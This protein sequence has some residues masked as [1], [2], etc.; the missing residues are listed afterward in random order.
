MMNNNYDIVYISPE[1]G[2]LILENKNNVIELHPLWLRERALNKDLLDPI[3]KQRKY[4]HSFFDTNLKVVSAKISNYPS[5]EITFSD[6]FLG[7]FDINKIKSEIG[8]IKDNESPPEIES[9]K[10]SLQINRIDWECLEDPI[11]LK[12]M[13]GDFFKYGFCIMENTP[14]E[15]NSLLHL[16]SKFGYVRHTHWGKLF[17][18]K[19]KKDPTDTAY[20]DSALSSHTDNPY[21][22][23]IPGIQFLH[24][25]ENNVSGGLSTL[26]DGIALVEQLQTELPEHSNILERIKVRF[27]YEG[28]SAILENWGSII[29]R[30]HK[31]IVNRI[32]L[33]NRLDYVPALD[34]KSLDLFYTGRKRLNELSNDSNFQ[35]QFPFQKG[36]LLMMDNY[37]LLHGR[38]KY[39]GNEGSRYLQGCYTDHDGV[40]SLYRMLSNGSKATRVPT[41]L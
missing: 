18:V 20:T 34:K 28:P 14:S 9:W 35:I 11:K 38:T 8:W 6:S 33:S 31:N 41:E 5:L 19:I 40:T 12:T 17:N 36:T 39:N 23:P 3:S 22:E 37:R 16:A 1:P 15:N 30:N 25:L 26:V 7:N 2:S 29:E 13:L 32:R 27:R 4:E 10:S 24:F 21:R